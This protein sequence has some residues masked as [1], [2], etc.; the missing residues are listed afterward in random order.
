VLAVFDRLQGQELALKLLRTDRPTNA[1]LLR[2]EFALLAT[3]DHPGVLRV[4]HMGVADGAVYLT[5][6]LLDGMRLD[7]YLNTHPGQAECQGVLQNLL[8]TLSWLH[9]QAVIHADIKPANILVLAGAGH[10]WPILID[11]GLAQ[12]VGRKDGARG[13]TPAFMA[14]ELLSGA[15]KRP[16]AQTDL[17]SLGR[18]FGDWADK[19]GDTALAEVLNWMCTKNPKRRPATAD[20]VLKRL[21][22]TQHPT[23]LGGHSLASLWEKEVADVAAAV[24]TNPGQ[25]QVQLPASE[26]ADPFAHALVSALESAGDPVMLMPQVLEA[27][28]DLWTRLVH[29]LESDPRDAQQSLPHVQSPKGHKEGLDALSFRVIEALGSAP[30]LTLVMAAPESMT[31]PDRHVLTRCLEAS[32]DT[33]W[34]LLSA[35]GGHDIFEGRP[36]LQQRQL[37]RPG[38]RQMKRFLGLHGV[39]IPT[40]ETLMKMLVARTGEGAAGLKSLLSFWSTT[41]VLV[42]QGAGR[43]DWARDLDPSALDA[44]DLDAVWRH[45]WTTLS[46]EAK[47]VVGQ[48]MAL[49]GHG[50][51]EELKR[52]APQPLSASPQS[53][54]ACLAELTDAGWLHSASGGHVMLSPPVEARLRDGRLHTPPHSA[55]ERIGFIEVLREGGPSEEGSRLRALAQLLS[56]NE[57]FLDGTV[58]WGRLAD[59]LQSRLDTHE[60]GQA[61]LAAAKNALASDSNE[62]LPLA[63]DRAEQ[64]VRLLEVAGEESELT[65]ALEAT[66]EAAHALGTEHARCR[67]ELTEARAALGRG[68]LSDAIERVKEGEKVLATLDDSVAAENRQSHLLDISLL[69]GAAYAGLGEME[70]AVSALEEAAERAEQAGDMHSAGRVANNLGNVHLR[71]GRLAQ[72]EAAYARSAA[73]KRKTGDARGRRIAQSNRAL[74]LRKMG[75]LAEA[76]LLLEATRTLAERLGDRRGMATGRLV[77]ALLALDLGQVSWAE[78]ELEAI[79][80][81]DVDSTVVHANHGILKVR[82]AMGRGDYDQGYQWAQSA[83]DTAQKAGL[84][85]A[86]RQA[87]TLGMANRLRDT[88]VLEDQAVLREFLENSD[89][90]HRQAQKVGSPAEIL[91]LEAYRAYILALTGDWDGARSALMEIPLS[92]QEALGP[93]GTEALGLLGRTARLL[94]MTELYSQIVKLAERTFTERWNASMELASQTP[95]DERMSATQTAVA[96]ALDLDELLPQEGQEMPEEMAMDRMLQKKDPMSEQMQNASFR[97][98]ALALGLLERGLAS[99]TDWARALKR[100]AGADSCTIYAVSEGQP[101]SIAQFPETHSDVERFQSVAARLVQAQTPFVGRGGDGLIEALGFPLRHHDDG[102]VSGVAFF[103]WTDGTPESSDAV[104]QRLELSAR[105]AALAAECHDLRGLSKR[106]GVQ[107]SEVSEESQR[108]ADFHADEMNKLRDTLHHTQTE[109]ELR[110]SY[111]QIVHQSRVMRRV[112]RTLDKITDSDVTVLVLGES[113]VGKEVLSRTLHHNGSRGQGPFVAENCGAVP[114]DLFESVFFGHVRGAFTGANSNHRGLLEQANGGTLFL[115]EVGELRPEHQVK[116]LRVIQER[117]FRPVGAPRE[118]EADFRLVAATN[119]DLEGMVKEGTFREDLYY[120]LSVVSVEI[121]PLRERRTD[122]LLLANHLL[123]AHAERNGHLL[124]LSPAAADILTAY[125]WP[126]NV[127]EL[128]NELLRASVLTD[129]EVI[130]PRVFSSRIRGHSSKPKEQ[131]VRTR[132]DGQSPLSDVVSELEREVVA[133][134]LEMTRGGKAKAARMLGISRPGLDAKLLR[135]DIDVKT[136][137]GKASQPDVEAIH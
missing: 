80:H 1:G 111:D 79:E 55:A 60:A 70:A 84:A 56:A 25:Y 90:L 96:R 27:P 75:H 34:V 9:G 59:H 115:D 109:V 67:L 51:A 57:S 107:L 118:L 68:A 50:T 45:L 16:T 8:G 52:M 33:N 44:P 98:L 114:V 97:G 86:E 69:R 6:D 65:E 112:L 11:F 46:D 24:R 76:H 126:G 4:H 63:L 12:A 103:V 102:D 117:R 20:E 40:D 82:L 105:L 62:A 123:N 28:L 110:Y 72:A 71:L 132:W 19:T 22:G 64:A 7:A 108:L 2:E 10:P 93:D 29:C 49:G 122:I 66:R 134:A 87:R 3:L 83:I 135:H 32:T 128:D 18:C 35:P 73:I 136:Y 127:R 48:L 26:D 119:R 39:A 120:R 125:A 43:W 95:A 131:S 5:T 88:A 53:M 38:R 101:D 41:G 42:H 78:G 77:S 133:Q 37:R 74:A 23:R 94:G 99:M 14:P 31:A 47:Q 54:F 130:E 81:M 137:S 13:G 85:S 21:G 129:G 30:G 116:L 36:E 106:L 58:A 100:V 92:G 113:G 15:R 91:I 89:A 104:L 124:R 61:A 17:F 121:P